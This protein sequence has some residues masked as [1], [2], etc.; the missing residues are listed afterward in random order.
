MLL[1]V[2]EGNVRLAKESPLG[3]VDAHYL[4]APLDVR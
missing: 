3:D 2:N 4:C 1:R